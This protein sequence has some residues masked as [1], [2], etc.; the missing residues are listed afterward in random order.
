[1]ISRADGG[2][3]SLRQLAGREVFRLPSPYLANLL[4]VIATIV[5]CDGVTFVPRRS[6]SVFERPGTL[7][8]SVGGA[9]ER[10]EHPSAALRRET[11]EEW[12]LEIQEDEIVFFAL[13]ISGSTG[14]P[15]LLGMVQSRLSADQICRRYERQAD[16]E[17]FTAFQRISLTPDNAAAALNL[18]TSGDWSQPSDQA[19]FYLTLV[20]MVLSA[21]GSY[22]LPIVKLDFG[23]AQK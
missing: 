2:L 11:M 16:R 9:L 19:A 7:Q 4:N 3:Q 15:D 12:G 5:S 23:F 20:R 22:R 6:F 18:L 13:G 21:D 14:E 17:E 1:M 8:T 10:G